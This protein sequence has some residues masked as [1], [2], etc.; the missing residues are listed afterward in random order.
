MEEGGDFDWTININLPVWILW[1]HSWAMENFKFMYE[2]RIFKNHQLVNLGEL[3]HLAHISHTC[4]PVIFV[5]LST[6]EVF[7]FNLLCCSFDSE[8][9]DTGLDETTHY[10]IN[11]IA[12]RGL[13]NILILFV[14]NI[15]LQGFLSCLSSFFT[16][17]RARL[18]ND[19]NCLIKEIWKIISFSTA[20]LR[21]IVGYMVW[22]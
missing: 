12:L 2:I 21:R 6:R 19:L 18:A 7:N 16:P 22:F 14:E 5:L 4:W 11:E 17:P 15:F 3:H 20:I 9:T 13:W 1:F 10:R 8:I